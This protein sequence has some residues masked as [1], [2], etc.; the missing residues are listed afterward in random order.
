MDDSDCFSLFNPLSQD[1]Y[2][3]Y[4]DNWSKAMSEMLETIL[5]QGN[6]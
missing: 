4:V 3:F 2:S 6:W 5:D 1:S